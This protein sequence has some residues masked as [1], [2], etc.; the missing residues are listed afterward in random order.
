MLVLTRRLGEKIVI[1]GVGTVQP[2]AV[3]GK[4]VRIALDIDPSITVHREE[5]YLRTH[6]EL[7]TPAAPQ[8]APAA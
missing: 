8:E 7:A 6:P 4:K 1:K 3:R 5:V 2:I